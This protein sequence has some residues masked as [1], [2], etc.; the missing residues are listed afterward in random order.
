MYHRALSPA[1]RLWLVADDL[2]APFTIGFVVEGEGRLDPA[3][4]QA[5]A[6]AAAEAVPGARLVL[7]RFACRARWEDSGVAPGIGLCDPSDWDGRAP[8]GS[9]LTGRRL[10][11]RGGPTLEVLLGEGAPCR[12]VVRVHHAVMDG[13]GLRTF[14][15]ELF[16]ALRGEAPR[17]VVHADSDLQLARQLGIDPWPLPEERHAAVT[18]AHDGAPDAAVWGRR[19]LVGRWRR[20]LP[21]VAAIVAAHGHAASDGDLALQFPVDLRRHLGSA[22]GT[23]NLTGI[24][25]LPVARGVTAEAIDA[26]LQ[27]ALEARA[28]LGWVASIGGLLHVP[29]ALMV[30]AGARGSARTN[31]AGDRY[32]ASAILSNMGSLP[33]DAFE[34]PDFAPTTAYVVPPGGRATAALFVFTRWADHT[35]MVVAMPVGLASG[36]RMDALLDDIVAG[37]DAQRV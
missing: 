28:E 3:R 30:W 4:W 1:E 16:R 35:E 23:G 36:G 21:K 22:T 26:D 27:Q 37:M 20:F 10:P 19:T 12:V 2:M 13:V 32:G 25:V 9:A 11:A 34:A 6:A 7:R 31:A 17:P 24:V 5:A 8:G 14:V 15:I 29:H 33:S 18:G